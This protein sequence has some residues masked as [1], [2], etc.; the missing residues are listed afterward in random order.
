MHLI[1]SYANTVILHIEVKNLLQ[2]NCQSNIEN[3]EK[4]VTIMIEK[5][6]IYRTKKVFI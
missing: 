4:N 1:N 2:N 6:L 5:C 3:Q